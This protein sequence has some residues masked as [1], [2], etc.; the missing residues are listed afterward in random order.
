MESILRVSCNGA[1]DINAIRELVGVS[2]YRTDEP[3]SAGGISHC[4]FE[5]A[6]AATFKV[7]VRASFDW[8]DSRPNIRR[9][10][11]LPNVVGADVDFATYAPANQLAS[12]FTIDADTVAAA[13]AA[14]LS[15]TISVYRTAESG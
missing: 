11:L 14:D 13:A 5:V 3:P 8:I 10:R 7:L 12:Y 1:P 4:H 15:I 2:P 9:L 6:K